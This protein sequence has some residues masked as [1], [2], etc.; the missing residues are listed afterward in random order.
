MSQLTSPLGA[1]SRQTVGATVAEL[2]RDRIRENYAPGD[3][4]ESEAALAAEFGAS[5]RAV[6]DALR[7]LTQQGLIETHQG[8]RA[9]VGSLRPVAVS[10]YFQM[11]LEEDHA[12]MADLIEMRE[13]LESRA[14]RYA[15]ERID[16]EEIAALEQTFEA[17]ENAADVDARVQL[18]LRFHALISR[19][20]G[21]RFLASLAESM[22]SVLEEE[23]R[24]GHELSHG[25]NHGKSDEEH[26]LILD[27]IRRRDPE[28][29]ELAMRGH[30]L[31]VAD[32]WR[33]MQG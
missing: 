25:R 30:L 3:E 22:S 1:G 19:A 12:S 7:I 32:R 2:L 18:D 8:K 26:A 14:A 17:I 10:G 31:A 5:Q 4:L 27:A 20:S 11:V 15:A 23:R 28:G 6:R 24:R 16:D 21:N 29:A 9:T 13:A 33:A